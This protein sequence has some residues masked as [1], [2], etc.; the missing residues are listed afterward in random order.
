MF[1]CR[2]GSRTLRSRTYLAAQALWFRI[3]R[4]LLI[5]ERGRDD[6]LPKIGQKSIVAVARRRRA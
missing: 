4:L 5:L 6:E 1:G 3:Y 2:T